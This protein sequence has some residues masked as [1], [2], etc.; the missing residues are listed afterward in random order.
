MQEF[1]LFNFYLQI[2]KE[3]VIIMI[4]EG[5]HAGFT[6]STTYALNFMHL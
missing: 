5:L 3:A 1:T 2:G 4:M 6:A